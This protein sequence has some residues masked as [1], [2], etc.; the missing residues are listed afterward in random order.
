MTIT[1]AITEIYTT[2]RQDGIPPDQTARFDITDGVDTY[3]F[4]QSGLA[5]GLDRAAIQSALNARKDWLW[6]LAKQKEHDSEIFKHVTKWRLI[7]ALML[8]ILDEINL[9]R[10]ELALNARTTEQITTAIKTKL[11]EL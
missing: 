2:D 1:I 6:G 9:L 7:K 11:E 3:S 8:V 5:V 4:S 10:S